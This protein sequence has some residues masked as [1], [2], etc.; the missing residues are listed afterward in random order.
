MTHFLTWL[1][2]FFIPPEEANAAAVRNYRWRMTG[3]TLFSFLTAIFTLTVMGNGMP[4]FGVGRL[5]WATEIGDQIAL[6]VR[7]S[8]LESES[9]NRWTR[10]DRIEGKL[11]DSLAQ[12]KAQELRIQKLKHCT[13][14]PGSIERESIMKEIER[15]QREFNDIRG[16]EYTVPRCADL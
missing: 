2:N 16:Y 10:M 11:N 7:M 9:L 15:L 13:A 8:K 4:A 14:V 5:V 3:I 12:G 6:Q 1:W